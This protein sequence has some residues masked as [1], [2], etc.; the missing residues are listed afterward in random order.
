MSCC[1]TKTTVRLVTLCCRGLVDSQKRCYEEKVC[2]NQ[3]SYTEYR[4][5]AGEG[6]ETVIKVTTKAVNKGKV[7]F[8]VFYTVT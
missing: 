8:L 3:N 1:K 6:R 4:S 7:K 2:R 5:I